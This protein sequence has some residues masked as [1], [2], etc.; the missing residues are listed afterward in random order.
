VKLR[1]NQKEYA[2]E[3]EKIKNLNHGGTEPRRKTALN[4]TWSK[5]HQASK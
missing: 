1:R 3:I 4:Q 2:E 5:N